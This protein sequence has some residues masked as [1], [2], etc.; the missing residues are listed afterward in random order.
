MPPMVMN[1][2]AGCRPGPGSCKTD[3]FRTNLCL[4]LAVCPY[5]RM[6]ICSSRPHEPNCPGAP[7]CRR[8]SCS[9]DESKIECTGLH[10]STE[11][12]LCQILVF[13]LIFYIF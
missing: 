10:R 13:R 7:R 1:V 12:H 11:P 9:L 5:S 2:S 8:I 3:E 4:L 6:C